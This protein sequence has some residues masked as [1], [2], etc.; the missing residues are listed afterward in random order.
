[1]ASNVD[2]VFITISTDQWFTLSKLER[3]IL[4]FSIPNA[5]LTILITKA[6]YDEQAHYLMKQIEASD[7][8]EKIHKISIHD[9]ESIRKIRNQLTKNR[10]QFY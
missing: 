4:T 5:A 2:H 9:E 10:L 6:D 1:M 7:F 3:Y 8:N